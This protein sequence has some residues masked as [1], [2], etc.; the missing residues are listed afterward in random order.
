MRTG[1]T[2]LVAGYWLALFV[3]T[4]LPRIPAALTMPGADKWQHLAAYAILALLLAARQSLWQP[5]NWKSL[6]RIAAIVAIYGV[7]DELTQIPVG[8]HA[9]VRDWY[10]DV[11]GCTLG[12]T[13]FATVRA[14]LVRFAAPSRP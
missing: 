2:L 7:V 5:L 9:D 14:I 13:V 1:F 3:A 11:V 8:R 12:L 10:A 6:C 4:H